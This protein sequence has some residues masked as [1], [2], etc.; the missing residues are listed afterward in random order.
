MTPRFLGLALVLLAGCRPDESLVAYGAD[1]VS[2][3]LQSLNGTTFSATASI[4]FLDDGAVSGQGPCN[5][6]SAQQNAPYPWIDIGPILSTKRACADLD[7]ETAYFKALSEMQFAEL[8]GP[9]MVLSNE[10]GAEMVFRAQHGGRVS[11]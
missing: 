9:L 7:A 5:G 4:Q 8:S 2:W 1:G 10:A 3:D 11:P 6:F